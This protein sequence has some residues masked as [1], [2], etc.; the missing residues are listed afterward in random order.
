METRKA[1]HFESAL[2]DESKEQSLEE[3]LRTLWALD[4]DLSTDVTVLFEE[5]IIDSLANALGVSGARAMATRIGASTFERPDR[6][7]EILDSVFGEGSSVLRRDIGER[8]RLS[9]S[10]LVKKELRSYSRDPAVVEALP[11]MSTWRVK[12]PKPWFPELPG[13]PRVRVR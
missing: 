3:D 10:L 2:D 11:T 1:F 12:R 5:A 13:F 8:F 9:I 4:S 6:A 7:L